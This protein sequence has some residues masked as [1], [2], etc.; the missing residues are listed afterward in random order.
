MNSYEHP[1]SPTCHICSYKC[2]TCSGTETN[3]HTCSDVNRVRT[4]SCD[5]S[6]GF[7][8]DG[9]SSVCYECSHKC[10]GCDPVDKDSCTSCSHI[11]RSNPPACGC[12]NGFYDNGD[13]ECANCKEGCVT[14]EN[15]YECL[16][17]GSVN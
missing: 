9:M 10:G 6:E 11:T 2:A 3:C 12:N 8:D 16:T 5:C 14:C 7:Y 1:D 13:K 4:P 15:G 17:C